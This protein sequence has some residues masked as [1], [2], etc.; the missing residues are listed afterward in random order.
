MCAK[1]GCLMEQ[2]WS[3]NMVTMGEILDRSSWK[4]GRTWCFV[5]KHSVLYCF[6]VEYRQTLENIGLEWRYDMC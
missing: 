3:I 2:I 1:T 5:V 6:V 4:C